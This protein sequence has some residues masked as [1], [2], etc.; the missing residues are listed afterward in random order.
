[1]DDLKSADIIRYDAYVFVAVS[2]LACLSLVFLDQNMTTLFKDDDWKWQFARDITNIGLFENYFVPAFLVWT[3]TW[4]VIKWNLGSMNRD[5]LRRVCLQSSWLMYSLLGSGILTHI[6]KPIF[7]RQRPFVTTNFEPHVFNPMTTFF[8]PSGYF[9]SLP[10]G[11]AQVLFTVATFFAFSIPRFRV[12]FY[13]VAFLLAFTRVATRDHFFSDILIGAL[14][15]HLTTVTLLFWLF[16]R[17]QTR[18]N[19]S[20]V[21]TK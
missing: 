4:S 17:N 21:F 20:E 14:V 3:G 1:M 15:G 16:K 7:G 11:H 6:I 8:E 10:S 13:L 2:I 18:K 19:Y 9:H 12:G 5:V